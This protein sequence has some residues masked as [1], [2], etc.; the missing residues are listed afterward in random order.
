MVVVD[1]NITAIGLD[2][3]YFCSVDNSHYNIFFGSNKMKNK[4][5]S[6]SPSAHRLMERLLS[7]LLDD[8]TNDEE[9]IEFEINDNKTDSGI[10]L[11]QAKAIRDDL[12]KKYHPD[13]N[14]DNDV[15]IS[16][17]INLFYEEL[18]KKQII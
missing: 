5:K 3:Y 17:G 6:L 11:R 10:S 14:S 12:M 9:F 15:G 16:Q 2:G 1:C 13:V 7:M 4:K 18:Q 8:L